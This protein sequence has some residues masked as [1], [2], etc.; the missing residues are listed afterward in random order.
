MLRFSKSASGFVRILSFSFFLTLVLTL[1]FAASIQAQCILPP[2]GMVSWW[3]GDG[4]S[5]DIMGTNNGTLV[6]G[7]TF[8]AGMA[9]QSFSFDGGDDYL[10]VG[11]RP[12]LVMTNTLTVDA[13]IYPT[14]T[15]S[16]PYGGIIV[17]KEGE[18]EIGRY[19][20]GSIQWAFAN[21]VPGWIWIN[22]GYI[23]PQDQWTH[24]ALVYDAGVIRTYA[25][26]ALVHTY[27]GSGSIGD[28]Q[29]IENDFRIG[30]RQDGI[31]Y[32]SGLID[33][34]EIFNRALSAAEI[35]SIY[36]AGSDGKCRS[37]PGLLNAVLYTQPEPICGVPGASSS[38]CKK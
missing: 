15:G 25:N 12:E 4:S 8:A 19:P 22:T 17:N 16:M 29:P 33:E 24:I 5:N 26:G 3:P 18:Y 13:W 37:V 2:S 38:I 6:N 36:S 20:D 1:S 30:G 10:Q 34:V 11:A 21:A 27:A 28:V 7:A 32:F 14:G 9:G 31:Q 23:A 35:Q